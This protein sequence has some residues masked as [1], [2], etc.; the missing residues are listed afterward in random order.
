MRLRRGKTLKDWLSSPASG[1]TSM[2]MYMAA[3]S[4]PR[5]RMMKI[6][7]M[8]GRRRMKWTIANIWSNKPQGYSRWL[9]N[10]IR[11]KDSV[12][13]NICGRALEK[14]QISPLRCGRD[15][16]GEGGASGESSC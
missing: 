14:P 12:K 15:D 9:R 8:S 7:Y 11:Y 10:P 6:Q 3:P 1:I 2:R 16:K 13:V 4:G 5:K